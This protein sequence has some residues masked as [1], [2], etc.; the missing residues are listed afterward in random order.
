[1]RILFVAMTDSPHAA[2]WLNLLKDTGWD[3]YLFSAY[4]TTR[5][6]HYWKLSPTTCLLPSRSADGVKLVSLFPQRH[7]SSALEWSLNRAAGGPGWRSRWLAWAIKRLKPDIVHSLEMQKAGVLTLRARE[8]CRGAFPTWAISNY[9]SDVYLFGRLASTRPDVLAMLRSA[10]QYMAECER[11]LALARELGFKGE[12]LPVVPNCGGFD[13]P[14]LKSLMQ[15]GPTSARRVIAIKGY[16]NWAGRALTALKAVELCADA[17]E[18]YKIC[19]YL[20]NDDLR[21]AAELL[22]LE[23]GLD[24]QCLPGGLPHDEILHL[25]GRS[26]VSVGISISDAASTSMLESMAMGSFPIQTCTACADEW[27]EDGK[28]GFI[29][30]P[31]DPNLIAERLRQAIVD[32]ALVDRASELNANTAKERLDRVKISLS[33]QKAYESILM[34]QKT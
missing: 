32:D 8:R 21:I 17:L 23:T 20:A 9:G 18:G 33:V 13:L 16:Q 6:Q 19:F 25:H 26:R 10:D 5:T 1:M 29:V 15:P 4:I 12:M 11:D 24:I 2:G 3:I 7:A 27:I 34:Q 28:S 14:H 30:P 22:A 31:D